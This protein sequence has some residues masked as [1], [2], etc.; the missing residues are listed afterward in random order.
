MI[1]IGDTIF[2][3]D[4]I[5]FAQRT[6][7]Q[8]EPATTISFGFSETSEADQSLVPACMTFVGAKGTLLWAYLCGRA[9]DL[10]PK[11]QH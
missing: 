1:R 6:S 10:T 7:I 5:V 8:G 2:N 4:E 9:T 11:I 3:P